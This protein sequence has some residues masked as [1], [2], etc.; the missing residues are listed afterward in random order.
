MGNKRNNLF[1]ISNRKKENS[2]QCT[3]G[4]WR[5]IQPIGSKRNVDVKIKGSVIFNNVSIYLTFSLP[6]TARES[7]APSTKPHRD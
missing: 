5:N 1:Q 3:A 2:L 6:L 7:V 4:S